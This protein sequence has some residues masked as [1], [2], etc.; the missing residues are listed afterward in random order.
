MIP[1]L[2]EPGESYRY[3]Q[4][5]EALAEQHLR[6]QGMVVLARRFR[7]R[8]G[9]IDLVVRDGE[10][11]VFVEVKA[12]RST[13]RYRPG[14]ALTPLKRRRLARTALAYLQRFDRPERPCRF[15]LV[16]VWGNLEGRPGLRH[17]RDAF[18][19]SCR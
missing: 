18:R 11:L 17:V 5:A 9:E 13:A 3:G 14:E 1:V 15:D 10:E 4:G 6:R 19:P 16:E 2:A 12:R 7:W 8:H